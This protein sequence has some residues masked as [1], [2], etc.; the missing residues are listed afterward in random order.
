MEMPTTLVVNGVEYVRR[1]SLAPE[2]RQRRWQTVAEVSESTGIPSRTIYDA[3]RSGRLRSVTPNGARRGM[4]TTEAWV[5][6]W[7]DGKTPRD[8]CQAK[9]Q[10]V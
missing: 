1:D 10:G 2:P 3:I 9:S 7:L 6:E 8:G 5:E 4:R